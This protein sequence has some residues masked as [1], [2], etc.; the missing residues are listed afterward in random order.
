MPAIETTGI[1]DE[2]RLNT[3]LRRIAAILRHDLPRLGTEVASQWSE[4]RVPRLG[5]SLAFYTLLSLAPLLVIVV[6]VAG[7]F[8]GRDAVEGQLVW[9]IQ[10]IVGHAGAETVQ[11][12]LKSTQQPGAGTLASILGSIALAVGATSG[13]AELRDGLNVIW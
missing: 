12:L 5:A 13:I 7:A 2:V 9:Q 6:A 11:N 1:R 4:H 10:D 3:Q 8:F